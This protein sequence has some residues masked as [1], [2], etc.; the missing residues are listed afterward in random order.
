MQL[1][2]QEIRL[3]RTER[4]LSSLRQAVWGTPSAGGRR[5][6][7]AIPSLLPA[8]ASRRSSVVEID[9]GKTRH[10]G[11]VIAIMMSTELWDSPWVMV[12]DVSRLAKSERRRLRRV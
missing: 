1:Q 11:G 8:P 6:A 12:C 3:R 7:R 5:P 10:E 4:L 2:R 9:D